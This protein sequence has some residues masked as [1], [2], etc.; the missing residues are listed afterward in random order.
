MKDKDGKDPQPDHGKGHRGDHSH[1]GDHGRPVPHHG[2]A[3]MCCAP[4]TNAK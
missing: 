2:S 3:A 4:P 1:H